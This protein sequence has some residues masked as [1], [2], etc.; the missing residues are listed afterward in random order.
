[1]LNAPQLRRRLWSRSL[2]LLLTALSLIEPFLNVHFNAAGWEDEPGLRLQLS[3][4]ALQ[5][6]L[7]WLQTDADDATTQ[8]LIQEATLFVQPSL[9]ADFAMGDL[10]QAA[11]LVAVLMLLGHWHGWR[12]NRTRHATLARLRDLAHHAPLAWVQPRCCGSPISELTIAPNAPPRT[13]IT[14]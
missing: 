5:P 6:E 11:V 7:R 2:I 14:C 13:P 8:T 10:L 12:G 1:M 4:H 3:G 9:D